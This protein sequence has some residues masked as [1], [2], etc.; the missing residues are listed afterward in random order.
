MNL[1]GIRDE[2]DIVRRHFGESLFASGQLLQPGVAITSIDVGSG[3]G[4]PG[5]A[6]KIFSPLL[7]QTLVESHGMKA[8]FLREVIRAIRLRDIRVYEGRA[9]DFGDTAELVTFRAVEKFERVL[10]SA[11]RLIGSGGRLAI[12][13]GLGQIEKAKTLLPGEWGTPIPI[14]ESDSRALVVWHRTAE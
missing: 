7:H 8:T 3:A 13:V 9:E 12:L 2:A 14:P 4:V 11:A 5:L 6:M 1:T 10:D